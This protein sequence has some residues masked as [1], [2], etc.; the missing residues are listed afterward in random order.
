MIQRVKT[1]T[2]SFIRV[3]SSGGILWL[4]SHLHQASHISSWCQ[5]LF[6]NIKM[7]LQKRTTNMTATTPSACPLFRGDGTFVVGVV[8]QEGQL[9]I[10]PLQTFLYVRLLGQVLKVMLRRSLLRTIMSLKWSSLATTV[11]STH[12]LYSLQEATSSSRWNVMPFGSDLAE[13]SLPSTLCS[14]RK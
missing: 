13:Q 9:M 8:G 10:F 3:F 1:V 14:H 12:Q 4:R 2:R 6:Y 7:R 11:L 5:I